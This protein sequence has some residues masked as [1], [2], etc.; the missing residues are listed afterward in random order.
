[1][2]ILLI[3][4]GAGTFNEAKAESY[5]EGLRRAVDAGY[6]VL[7][8]GGTALD[9]VIVLDVPRAESIQRL[10]L[11]AVEQGRTDDTEDVISRRL[12]IY[13]EAT[14]PILE[15]YEG[16]GIVDS[17]DGVGDLDDITARIVAALEARGL[18]RVATV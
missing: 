9:A 4:G 12:D 18:A 15:V 5:R 3:H 13:D 11:R 17:V 16:R 1:M 6:T 7:T 14:A 8:A 2:A 10:T